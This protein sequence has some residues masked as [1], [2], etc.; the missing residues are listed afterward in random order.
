MLSRRTFIHRSAVGALAIPLIGQ[1]S[2]ADELGEH[3]HDDLSQDSESPPIFT[4]LQINDLHVQSEA[5]RNVDS[6]GNRIARSS[7]YL[8]AGKRALWL[9]DALRAGYYFKPS[10]KFALAIGDMIHGENLEAIKLDME[11]FNK[12]IYTDFPIPLFPAVGNHENRQ[13][14][15]NDEYEEPYIQLFGKD[16]VNYSFVEDNIHFIVI[17]NSG[18]WSVSD[19]TALDRRYAA[20]KQHL[21]EHPSLH[22]IICCH[23]PL[24]PV[25]EKEI[26]AQSFGFASYYTK[27]QDLLDLIEQH[28]GKVLAVLSGHLHLSGVVIKDG[29]HHISLSGLASYPHDMGLYSV[30]KDRIKVT[31]IR[32]PSNMLVP[33]TNIHG[34]RKYGKDFIDAEHPDYTTYIMGN[35]SERRFSIPI[36]SES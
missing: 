33:E 24:I 1:R 31:L 4:F 34:A 11:W 29:I 12:R 18:T 19:H 26:L 13:K 32:V 14:E 35:A 25:R 8:D 15:G 2:L 17:N 30:Y 22:K 9:T 28:K 21:E 3:T 5:S 7:G 10:P 6:S 20:L 27:E 23:V 16:R 36:P